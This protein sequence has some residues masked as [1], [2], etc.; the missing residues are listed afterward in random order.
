MGYDISN[1]AVDTRLMTERLIPALLRQASI[2]DL[3]DRASNLAVVAAQANRWGL[4]VTQLCDD[5]WAKQD[6][7]GIE[8][9]L[10]LPG[11]H[12][13]LSVWGRPFFIVAD[14][15]DES[16]A[17][18][19]SYME[20]S[21]EDLAAV[22][23]IAASMLAK[24]DAQRSLLPRDKHAAAAAI[25]D[26]FYPLAHHLPEPKNQ[27]TPN[28][29]STRAYLE[30]VLTT[31][32]DGWAQRNTDRI[33][34]S[35]VLDEPAAAADLARSAP[36]TLLN[37]A[38]QV[39]PG[40]MGRGYVWPTQLFEKIGVPV[41]HLFETPTAL[42]EPLVRAFPAI[43][44][45]FGTTIVYNYSLGGYVRPENVPALR[46]LLQKH[47]RELILAW[48]EPAQVAAMGPDEISEISADYQKILEPV[49]LAERNG[50]GFIEAAEIYSGFMGVM[51]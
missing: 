46:A 32:Q 44:E 8:E 48:M 51:N 37:L 43:E 12:S 25:V 19:A 47:E 27:E 49:V 33:I 2:G 15:V 41:S 39:L 13:D 45:S 10:R 5:L 42:F 17:A 11:F 16:L 26:T 36:Y 1:H 23:R 9:T 14:T 18:F 4:R 7:A 3:L 31:Y 21:H 6:D 50:Y 22:D 35:K 34:E 20:C 24:L 29:A 30:A 40:W 28:L 38:S